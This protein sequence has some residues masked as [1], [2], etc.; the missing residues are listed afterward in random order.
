MK[1]C[2]WLRPELVAQVGY[3]EWTVEGQL[4]HPKFLD[5]RDDKNPSEVVRE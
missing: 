3:V 1:V 5:L 4:R 2:R